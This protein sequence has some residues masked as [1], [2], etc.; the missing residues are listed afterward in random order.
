MAHRIRSLIPYLGKLSELRKQKLI[1]TQVKFTK[2]GLGGSFPALAKKIGYSEYGLFMEKVIETCLESTDL[3]S[4]GQG[5][6]ETIE[7]I[8]SNLLKTLES[9]LQEYF[10][11]DETSTIYSL[12]RTQF[13]TPNQYQLEWF[14]TGTCDSSNQNTPLDG[15]NIVGHPDLVNDGI[16]Y[17][18][19]TTGQFNRMRTEAIYQI[20]SYYCL[21]QLNE[22][23]I[24]GVGLILPAQRKIISYDLTGWDWIPF[25]SKVI[26]CISLKQTREKLYLVNSLD[27]TQIQTN[28][29]KVGYTIQKDQLLKQLRMNPTKPYQFFVNGNLK[30]ETSV[31]KSFEKEL[32]KYAPKGSVYIHSSY[33]FNLCE[34]FGKFKR[35]SDTEGVSWLC[36]K[37]GQL[38]TQAASWGIKGVVI[39]CGKSGRL[40]KHKPEYTL[41]RKID[42]MR[43]SLISI[44]KNT[45]IECPVLLETSSGQDGETLTKINELITFYYSLPLEARQKIKV[46]LDTCHVFA[47]GHDPDLYLKI[48]M[49]NNVPV[50]LIHFN[51]SKL[52]KG[53]F[54]DR[55]APFGSGYIGAKILGNVMTIA[56]EKGIDMVYE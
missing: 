12:V 11:I 55:H 23:P 5:S 37:V 1:P 52:P 9:N 44:S 45:Q 42:A 36:E 2:I 41:E 15:N 28:L 32:L 14:S 10:P 50:G 16:V 8:H 39:H 38:M 21:A 43:E 49:E 26:A 24:K 4:P 22:I 29:G 27:Y 56:L 34:P 48:L 40:P 46:C 30:T 3:W 7:T 31:S 53:S 20:L 47:S 54:R 6:S 13:K 35:E 25:W 33:S 17:D 18:I 19:K 51:D